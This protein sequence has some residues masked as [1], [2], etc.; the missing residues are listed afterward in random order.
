MSVRTIILMIVI[1]L[2]TAYK[3]SEEMTVQ[4]TFSSAKLSRKYCN[5]ITTMYH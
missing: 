2:Y 3:Q 4:I 1:F 5:D